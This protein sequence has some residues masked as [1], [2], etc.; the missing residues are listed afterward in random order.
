MK[1]LIIIA[2]AVFLITLLVLNLFYYRGRYRP[3]ATEPPHFE[4]VTT[5][6]PTTTESSETYKER[7]GTVLLDLAHLNQFKLEEL[8]SLARRILSR[9]YSLEYLEEP[10][11]SEEADA[12]EEKLRR[13]DAFAIVLPQQGFSEIEIRAVKRFVA[14]GG[15]LLLIADPTRTSQ[16]NSVATEFGLIFEPDFL[17]NMRQNE[18]NFGHIFLS[19]F[20][21]NELTEKLEKLVFYYTG[22]ISSEDRGIVFTDENTM[23][24]IIESKDRLSPVALT[25]DSKVLAIADLTFMT[26]PS[27]TVVDNN[28]FISNIVDWL[29]D[30]ERTFVLADFP[31]FFG[32]VIEITYADASLLKPGLE[33]KDLLTSEGK[34]VEIREYEDTALEETVFLGLFDDAE[35]VDGYLK[36]GNISI[37]SEVHIG[38]IGE[39]P[40]EDT[41]ILY[42]AESNSSHV[43][44][45]LSEKEEVLGEAIQM[46]ESGEF[47]EWLASDAL[48][49]YSLPED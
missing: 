34:A 23:S 38:G 16:I 5:E 24:S 36:S 17:Y 29:T 4:E 13:A 39:I 8:H 10:G 22:S 15:K 30:S 27:N 45:I 48:A 44:I 28:Q 40:Q 42:L 32:E 37:N 25:G 6:V 2:I 47:R 26:P 19:E 12:L 31:H 7:K 11:D 49:V 41:W 33:L 14:K 21:P 35:K 1:R 43:L 46:L 18:G 9:G 20:G 3:P